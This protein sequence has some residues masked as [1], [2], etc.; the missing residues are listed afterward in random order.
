MDTGP[1]EFPL[2]VAVVAILDID[3]VAQARLRRKSP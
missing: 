1:V 3:A 2:D